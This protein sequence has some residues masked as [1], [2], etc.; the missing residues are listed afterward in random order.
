[1]RWIVNDCFD[2]GGFA[3]KFLGGDTSVI[4]V[5]ELEDGWDEWC[6]LSCDGVAKGGNIFGADG[7]NNLLDEGSFNK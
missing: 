5:K 6:D 2:R 3:V 7:L 4:V 1:M